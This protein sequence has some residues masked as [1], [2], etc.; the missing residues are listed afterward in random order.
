MK[1]SRAAAIPSKQGSGANEQRATGKRQY[2]IKG[3]DAHTVDMV[4]SAAQKEGMKVGAWVSSRIEEAASRALSGEDK[5]DVSDLKKAVEVIGLKQ[6]EELDKIRSMHATLV[7][8]VMTQNK[9]MSKMI[10]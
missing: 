6:A 3:I 7:D 1:N 10:S 5:I 9:M 2:T 8:I 4:R